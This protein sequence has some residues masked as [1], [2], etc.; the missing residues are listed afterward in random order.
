MEDQIRLYERR[1]HPRFP[2]DFPIDYHCEDGSRSFVGKAVNASEGGLMVCFE[3]SMNT[4]TKVVVS[5]LFNLG[6]QLTEIKA[7]CQI[8]WKD[9]GL[10]SDFPG[11]QYGLK[12][13]EINK[14]DISKLKRLKT[15]T[16][17]Q[18]V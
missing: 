8:I 5:M 14:D 10:V 4:G 9:V 12:F 6:Y 1:R 2:I 17:D 3:Q 11:Y 7:R 18:M 15:Y 13:L 16:E